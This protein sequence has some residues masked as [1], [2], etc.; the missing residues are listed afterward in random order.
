MNAW[1][2]LRLATIQADLTT[3]R[4]DVAAE[5]LVATARA[6]DAR[7]ISSAVE[8]RTGSRLAGWPISIASRS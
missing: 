5:R 8:S 1:T 6:A 2:N 7:P 4:A 3:R